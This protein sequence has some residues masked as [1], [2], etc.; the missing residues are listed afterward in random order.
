MEH[1]IPIFDSGI[2]GGVDTIKALALRAKAVF[3]GRPAI[4]GLAIA[5]KVSLINRQMNAA[6]KRLFPQAGAKQ[7]S[8]GVLAD[9]DRSM[10]LAGIVNIEGCN[11]SMI[12]RVEYGGDV[13]SSN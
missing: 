13:K 8:Q 1:P 9:L 4:Y 6:D 7:V 10:G 11:R 2:R 3:V 5:G 12:R